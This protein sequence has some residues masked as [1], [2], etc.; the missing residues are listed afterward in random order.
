MSVFGSPRVRSTV[1]AAVPESGLLD[2][3]GEL[4]LFFLVVELTAGRSDRA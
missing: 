1:F 4:P 3:R 2:P